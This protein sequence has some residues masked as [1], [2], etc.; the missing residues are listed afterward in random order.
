MRQRLSQR[1][2]SLLAVSLTGC[3]VLL[4]AACASPPSPTSPPLTAQAHSVW[5]PTSL[6]SETPTSTNTPVPT[7]TSTL[8]ATATATA[9]S[10]PVAVINT[11]KTAV[12]AGP[13]NIGYDNVA[14]LP[15]GA[16]V[17]PVGVFG[18][19]VKVQYE[20]GGTTQE[21]FVL[22]ST[23]N[24]LLTDLEILTKDQVPW[25][26]ISKYPSDLKV[27]PT[28]K[29]FR[30]EPQAKTMINGDAEINFKITGTG[31]YWMVLGDKTSNSLLVLGGHD[32]S[33][34]VKINDTDDVKRK[35]IFFDSL[36]SKSGTPFDGQIEVRVFDNGKRVTISSPNDT[37]QD[38]HLDLTMLDPA[39]SNGFLAGGLVPEL[40][41][42]AGSIK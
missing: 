29:T 1:S 30:I 32:Q 23:L 11:D 21:G 24:T 37:F 38:Y 19:F 2:P 36:Q 31:Q 33:V 14:L 25:T 17:T 5:T 39:F 27:S 35:S 4:I 16:E 41:A 13:A 28:S 34:E 10:T 7:D 12:N 15:K 20:V 22:K 40:T 6:P 9:T 8:A 42:S 26:T 3:I 18:Q